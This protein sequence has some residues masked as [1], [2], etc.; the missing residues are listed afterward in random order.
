M[1]DEPLDVPGQLAAAA[2]GFRERQH[3]EWQQEIP[4]RVLQKVAATTP[5]RATPVRV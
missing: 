1:S 5:S 3:Q 2:E 4:W